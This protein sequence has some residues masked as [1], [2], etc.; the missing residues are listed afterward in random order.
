MRVCNSVSKRL[1]LKGSG[2]TP[3]PKMYPTGPAN[4]SFSGSIQSVHNLSTAFAKII[5]EHKTSLEVGGMGDVC[6]N[7]NNK[8]II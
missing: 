3:F 1:D 5:F 7:I 2:R 6:N 8:N 4:A